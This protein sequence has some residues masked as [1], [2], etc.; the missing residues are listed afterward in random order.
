MTNTDELLA[1]PEIQSAIAELQ[2]LILARFPETEFIIGE[3]SDPEGV[4]IRAIV[5]VDDPDEVSAVFI[6]RMVDIQVDDH[7]PVYVVPLRMAGREAALREH[8]AGARM[9]PA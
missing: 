8:Q 9:R 2:H 7:L 1:N 6:D 3:A 5:D 4:L